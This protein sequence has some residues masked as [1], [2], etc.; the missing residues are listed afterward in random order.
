[1]GTYRTKIRATNLTLSNKFPFH[2]LFLTGV[3]IILVTISGAAWRITSPDSS[4]QCLGLGTNGDL[5]SVGGRRPCSGRGN[6]PQGLLYPE[7]QHRPPP[8]SYQASMQEYRLRLVDWGRES[9]QINRSERVM[10]FFRKKQKRRQFHI[11]LTFSPSSADCSCWTATDRMPLTEGLLP[12]PLHP[13][14]DQI[15]EAS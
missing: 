8:P 2:P 3:G 10:I 6:T 7:F 11:F 14:T 4:Q 5:L 1:M 12:L 9:G 15:V 13:H